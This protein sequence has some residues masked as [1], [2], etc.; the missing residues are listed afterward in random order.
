MRSI[1]N[2]MGI[3]DVHA[4]RLRHGGASE[5]LLQGRRK[6]EEVKDRGGW[7]T[8]SSLKRYGKQ[9]KVQQTL[10]LLSPAHLDFCTWATQ[11]MPKVLRGK[12]A[13]RDL[14]KK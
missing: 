1:G 9:G 10:H 3:E 6:R 4:Y 5:D 8:E 2:E 11:A 12:V 13:P 14:P 7:S